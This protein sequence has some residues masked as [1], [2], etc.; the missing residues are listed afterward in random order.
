MS[1][2]GTSSDQP[3]QSPGQ[4][5]RPAEQPSVDRKIRVTNLYATPWQ[6]PERTAAGELS[7]YLEL[8]RCERYY[9]L[10]A[11]QLPRVLHREV[12]DA[13][14]LGFSR[15]ASRAGQVAAG[16]VWLF[17][18]PSGQVIATLSIDVRGELA[19]TIDLLEDCYFGDVQIDGTPTVSQLVR[20][21]FQHPPPVPGTG[22]GRLQIHGG[23]DA[24]AAQCGDLR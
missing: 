4:D 21:A 10:S 6:L 19:D 12:L 8:W 13:G 14:A 24:G 22:P 11:D 16:R 20:D 2:P 1:G 17:Q 23:A 9:R 18:L 15:W 3:S 5:R 7:D